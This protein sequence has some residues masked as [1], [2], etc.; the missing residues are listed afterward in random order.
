MHPLRVPWSVGVGEEKSLVAHGRLEHK[1]PVA[2]GERHHRRHPMRPDKRLD[3]IAIEQRVSPV[4]REHVPQRGRIPPPVHHNAPPNLLRTPEDDRRA[5]RG[6]LQGPR[7]FLIP[8][9]R[10]EFEQPEPSG[11]CDHYVCDRA[12]RRHVHYLVL[13]SGSKER[14]CLGRDVVREPPDDSLRGVDAPEVVLGLHRGGDVKD[15]VLARMVL[16]PLGHG[17]VVAPAAVVALGAVREPVEGGEAGDAALLG[18][19][20]VV[21]GVDL[22]EDDGDPLEAEVRR[23]LLIHRLKLLTVGAPRRIELDEHVRRRLGPK[24]EVPPVEH[25]DV[26]VPLDVP[27]PLAHPP[28]ARPLLWPIVIVFLSTDAW[29]SRKRKH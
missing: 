7:L 9:V 28:G 11:F 5:D 4:R 15:R 18:D 10:S 16:D 17:L 22:R 12:V 13:G 23:H 26:V 3:A 8:F 19:G 21:H 2:R 27:V 14:L 6:A 25:Q 29:C 1:L 20:G 24:L